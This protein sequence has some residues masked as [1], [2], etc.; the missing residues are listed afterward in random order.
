MLWDDLGSFPGAVGRR[1]YGTEESRELF[2]GGSRLGGRKWEMCCSEGDELQ[3]SSK[4]QLPHPP[5]CLLGNLGC[6]GALRGSARGKAD[7]KTM[8]SPSK[9]IQSLNPKGLTPLRIIL[10]L[11]SATGSLKILTWLLNISRVLFSPSAS[12]V[13]RPPKLRGTSP[14]V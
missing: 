5:R 1:K 4:L 12:S 7:P 8:S 14:I 6:L 9:T 10:H 13:R 2:H 3:H 11:R